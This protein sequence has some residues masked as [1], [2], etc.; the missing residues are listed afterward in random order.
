MTRF[1]E[2]DLAKLGTLRYNMFN[3]ILWQ[4]QNEQMQAHLY[5]LA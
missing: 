3:R 1:G 5:E 4:S 2:D